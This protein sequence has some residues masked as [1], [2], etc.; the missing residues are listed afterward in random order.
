VLDLDDPRTP[1]IFAAS[2]QLDFILDNVKRI[3][4][5]DKRSRL[6]T[7]E[8]IRPAFA[9][10]RWL[11][12]TRFGQSPKIANNIDELE[13]Q[14]EKLANLSLQCPG[15]LLLGYPD[16]CPVCGEFRQGPNEYDPR[17]YCSACLDVIMPS[18]SSVQSC[19]EGF[20]TE[21]I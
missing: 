1:H 16:N 20:H 8:V 21:A 10:L 15:Q 13:R 12:K 19:E 6:F 14:T 2:W 11:N 4:L 18:L 3:S 5:S 7:L 17:P 9:A